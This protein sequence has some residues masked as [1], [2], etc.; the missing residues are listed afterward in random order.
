M[1][2][3]ITKKDGVI[4]ARKFNYEH[5]QTI[6]LTVDMLLN[7][8]EIVADIVVN[9]LSFEDKK[10]MREYSEKNLIGEHMGFGMWIRNTY[11]LWET[12]INLLT[13]NCVS[14]DSDQHPDNLSFEIMK[15]VVKVLRG[16]YKP[17]AGPT[18]ENF[19]TAMKILGDL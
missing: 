1:I 14:P 13:Q 8:D 15:L 12:E 6:G 4:D 5:N 16:E 11:G 17:N 9:R 19:D 3:Y 7:R 18:A 10:I 2:E